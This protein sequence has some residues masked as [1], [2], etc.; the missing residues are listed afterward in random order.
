MYRIQIIIILT[1]L[2]AVY[3]CKDTN[4]TTNQQP[5]SPS[6]NETVTS[7]SPAEEDSE[8]ITIYAWVEKLRLRSEPNTR[9]DILAELKEG[10]ELSYL[11]EKTPTTEKVSLRGQIY[12]E[13]WLKVRNKDNIIGWV[14]GGGVKFYKPRVDLSKTPYDDCMGIIKTGKYELAQKCMSRIQKEQLKKDKQYVT[15]SKEGI[16]FR[17]LSGEKKSLRNIRE[18]AVEISEDFPTYEY[19]YYIPQ[20]GYF[21][22]QVYGYESGSFLLVNDKSGQEIPIWGYPKP[23]PDF[24]HLLVSNADLRAGF[25]ANGL[26]VLGFTYEGFKV[27]WEKELPDFEPYLPKWLDANKAEISLSPPPADLSDR[28]PQMAELQLD[29]LGQWSFTI[30]D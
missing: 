21:V 11:N 22:V 27:V 30:E 19:R 16:D 13:P 3:S 4:S 5:A 14:Y 1:F 9:G 29:S 26:Q 2:F 23:S 8:V 6:S 10:D 20:M 7:A 17:L 24:K 15:Q 18:G 28:Q 12:D 25:Q